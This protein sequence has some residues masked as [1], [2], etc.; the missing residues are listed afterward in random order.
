MS[1]N[2]AARPVR[3]P[4]RARAV[5][6]L[7]LAAAL[8]VVAPL[9]AAQVTVSEPWVRGTVAP[10]KAT[11]AFM[12]LTSKTDAALVSAA[13]PAAKQVEIHEMAMVDNVMRMRP[14]RELALPAGKEVELRP[15]SYHVMLMGIDHQL[16]QGEV[17]P[18]TLT[19][20][21]RDGKTQT[22]EVKA[23]VREL[24]AQGAP[25]QPAGMGRH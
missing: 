12:K 24:A 17:I 8:A 6:S 21:D 14:I 10:Q 3:R 19:I 11:G 20:R 25:K 23:E 5:A 18:I 9:A 22:V 7:S 13:S 1:Q 4:A 16:K 15:G 2:L